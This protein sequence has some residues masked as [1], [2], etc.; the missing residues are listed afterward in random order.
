[1]WIPCVGDVAYPS[2]FKVE[3]TLASVLISTFHTVHA[4]DPGCGCGAADTESCACPLS[5]FP[6]AEKRISFN[7]IKKVIPT[8]FLEF[9]AQ[10]RLICL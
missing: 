3:R 6:S 4:L 5:K 9:D 7:E 2:H 8:P 1:M 10:K